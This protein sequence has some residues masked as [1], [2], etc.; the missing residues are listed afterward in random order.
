LP[1]VGL[2]DRPFEVPERLLVSAPEAF[3]VTAL[4]RATSTRT[5]LLDRRQ[6][7]L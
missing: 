3:M 4:W 5:F 2:V 7:W 1:F 6:A